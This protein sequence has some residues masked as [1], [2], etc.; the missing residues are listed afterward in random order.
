MAEGLARWQGKV[1]LITGASSGI[2]RATATR[3]AREGLR[4]ALSARN[5]GK[6]EDLAKTL[7]STGGQA[8]AFPADLRNAEDIRRM[9]D[10]VR[11]AWGGVDVM[12]NNA[13]LG[14]TNAL[15]EQPDAEWREMLEV[16]ILA[17][18]ICT[19]EALKDMEGRP[20]GQIIHISSI[21][22]HRVPAGRGGAFYAASKFAVRALADGL[23]FELVEKNSPVRLAQISP[24]VVET[25]FHDRATK[26]TGDSKAFYS[27]YQV[28]KPDDVADVIAYLLSTPPHVNIHDIIMRSLAQPH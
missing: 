24:G 2:G 7:Q 21:A 1:A 12:I 10:A 16:N 6:L 17:L 18:S 15:A 19:Q 28:L 20:E 25:E 5:A 23:R 27:Q 26:G 13:G 3:L 4:V 11:Q 9:F 14:Y 8:Q 22:G